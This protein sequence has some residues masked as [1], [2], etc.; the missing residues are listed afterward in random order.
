MT[1]LAKERKNVLGSHLQSHDR[2]GNGF[3][4]RGPIEY[5]S[6]NNKDERTQSKEKRDWENQ[7]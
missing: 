6:N 7:S 4:S 3:R 2:Y 1:N 5:R